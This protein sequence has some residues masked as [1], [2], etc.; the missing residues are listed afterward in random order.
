M[1]SSSRTMVVR[2][3]PLQNGHMLAQLARN[4]WAQVGIRQALQHAG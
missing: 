2:D 4:A 3:F 1:H